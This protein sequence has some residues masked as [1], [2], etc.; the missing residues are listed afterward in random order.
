[1]ELPILCL[2]ALLASVLTFFSG[3]GLGTLLLPAFALFFPVEQ[4]V[5]MTAVVHF[6]NNL[7]KLALVG[8]HLDRGVLLRFGLPAIVAALLGAWLLVRLAQFGPVFEW[9]GFGRHF[10]ATPIDL[11]VGALLLAFAAVDVVPRWR[12]SSFDARWMPLGGALSGFFGGLSGM[13]GALRSAFLARAGLD[14]RAF[15][16]TGVAIACLVDF[17]RL[18]VYAASLRA[19]AHALDYGVLAAAVGAAAAGAL[20]GNR[21]LHKVT[22]PG[23]QRVV[24]AMLLVVAL[25]MMSGV[26]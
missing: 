3:F 16:G 2:V 4:A 24:A 9:T 12:D 19:Q 10:A 25:G 26:L 11:V 23:V 5:A 7:F 14:T 18:G 22:M 17:T 8:R 20:I 15:I 21:L 6:L 13:Q 1:M